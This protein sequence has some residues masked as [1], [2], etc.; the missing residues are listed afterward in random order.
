MKKLFIAVMFLLLLIPV[1]GLAAAP[2]LNKS[3]TFQWEQPDDL[4]IITGWSL[5]MSAVTGSGYVKIVD[6]PYVAGSGPTFTT[7]TVLNVAGAPGA[8]ANRFFVL[9]ANGQGGVNSVY[10]NEASYGFVIP[11]AVPAAPFNLR[12][13]VTVGP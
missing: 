5:Y 10:S 11:Y 4:G 12:V 8:T 2:P 6:I 13:S 9:T 3:L 1:L 7:A